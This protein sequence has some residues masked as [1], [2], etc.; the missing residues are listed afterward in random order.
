MQKP[1]KYLPKF[2]SKNDANI[3]LLKKKERDNRSIYYGIIDR[4]IF[5]DSSTIRWSLKYHGLQSQAGHCP[6]SML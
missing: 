5:V 4:L 1:F 6:C 2:F 3:K